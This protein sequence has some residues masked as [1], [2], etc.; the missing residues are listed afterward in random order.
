MCR[1]NSTE[2]LLLCFITILNSTSVWTWN[3]LGNVKAK[4]KLCN[5][6]NISLLF[7][8]IWQKCDNTRRV[9]KFRKKNYSFT[10]AQIYSTCKIPT[11]P[12]FDSSFLSH[13]KSMISNHDEL[14]NRYWKMT[15]LHRKKLSDFKNSTSKRNLFS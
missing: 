11:I 6:W 5:L 15:I 7:L 14:L 8:E 13:H 10:A 1:Q 12:R 4:D 9:S 3:R 2:M